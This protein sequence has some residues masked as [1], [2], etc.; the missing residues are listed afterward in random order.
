[1]LKI[2]LLHAMKAHRGVEV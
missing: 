1:M 2:S